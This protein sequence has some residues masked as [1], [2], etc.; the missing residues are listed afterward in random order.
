[1]EDRKA[2][3]SPLLGE[4]IVKITHESGLTVYISKKNYQAAYAVFGTRY[5]SL[6]N[7]F[8]VDGERVNVPHGIAHF[9]E[10]KMFE[11][12]DGSDAFE[13]FSEH[14]ADAN[15]FTSFDRTAYIFSCTENFYSS[16][17]A[18]LEMVTTPHF[19]EQNVEKEKGIITQEIKMCEDRSTYRLYY[20]LMKALYSGY[21]VMIPVAGTVDS[22]QKID[23]DLLYK[24]YRAFYRM[25][26]MA[27]CV[28]GDVDEDKVMETVDRIIKKDKEVPA[29]SFYP[30][31][32]ENA[33]TSI[34]SDEM[35]VS[36]PLVAIGVKIPSEAKPETLEILCTAVFG[37]SEEF[38]S[39]LY[40][41]RLVNQYDIGCDAVRNAKTMI[42][43]CDSD[44]P[45]GVFE[46]FLAFSEKIRTEGVS[47]EA[48]D[49]AKRIHYAETL[50]KY[51][52]SVAIAEAVFD[53]FID[54]SD[55]IG[56]AERYAGV[57]LEE[58]NALAAEVLKKEKVAMSIVYPKGCGKE[59]ENS[60]K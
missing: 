44:D 58:V 20:N 9:L 59:T 38:Y 35:D 1:M 5:G 56:Q 53:G 57:T 27:L 36:K 39:E 31:E 46:R 47:L 30:E 19:T 40:E 12:E 3:S 42:V 21:P 43:E 45:H 55:F 49:R 13:K 18:L 50:R 4:Q 17:E 16:L 41:N 28:C 51:D 23:A 14:G 11:S 2:V 37:E 52:S 26:N 6:E 15:A 10:H 7:S 25:S 29:I 60:R 8:E 32:T 34:I 54:G 22:I 33:V 24:C 48:F